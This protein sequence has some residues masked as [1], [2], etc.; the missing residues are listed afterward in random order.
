MLIILQGESLR[1]WICESI[2]E[3]G[4]LGTRSVLTLVFSLVSIVFL[5]LLL[6]VFC[7]V[8]E[9]RNLQVKKVKI[10]GFRKL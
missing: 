4:V 5:L 6:V 9:M 1:G 7:L 8:P 10:A 2:D 3:A